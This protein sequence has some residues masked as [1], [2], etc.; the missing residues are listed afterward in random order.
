MNGEPIWRGAAPRCSADLL[1]WAAAHSMTR[2][3]QSSVQGCLIFLDH[4][5]QH[6][7]SGKNPALGPLYHWQPSAVTASLLLGLISTQAWETLRMQQL[8]HFSG[9]STFCERMRKIGI[10]GEEEFLAM[11]PWFL[12]EYGYQNCQPEGLSLLSWTVCAMFFLTN[13][14]IFCALISLSG[15]KKKGV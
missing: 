4:Q 5:L 13:T 8:W 2:D 6:T 9:C 12:K 3:Q 14:V 11:L 15:K 7:T 10:G 1:Q